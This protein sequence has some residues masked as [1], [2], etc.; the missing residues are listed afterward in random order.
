MPISAALLLIGLIAITG[1]PPFAPFMSEFTLIRAAFST[2]HYM[3]AGLVL[4]LLLV[5]FFGLGTT[6]LAVVQGAPSEKFGD[7]R[8]KEG[9][10]GVIPMF[11]FLALIIILGVYMPAFIKEI[12]SGAVEYLEKKS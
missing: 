5:V 3:V 1:A 2:N 11:F 4:T 8:L 9:L 7:E 6:V 10:F 12:L